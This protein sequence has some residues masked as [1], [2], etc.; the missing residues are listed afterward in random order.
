MGK[1]FSNPRSEEGLK[2]MAVKHGSTVGC[3]YAE[4]FKRYSELYE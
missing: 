1:Y 4:A 3:R 2:A